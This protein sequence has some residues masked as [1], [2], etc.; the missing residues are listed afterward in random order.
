MTFGCIFWV[1]IETVGDNGSFP[2]HGG[3]TGL[4]RMLFATMGTFLTLTMIY[5][6]TRVPHR[7]AVGQGLARR[8]LPPATIHEAIRRAGD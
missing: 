6:Q 7:P 8:F 4:R 2:T 3:M 1:Q 5:A